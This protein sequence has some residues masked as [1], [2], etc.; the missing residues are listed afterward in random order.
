MS[1]FSV[2]DV[3]RKDRSRCTVTGVIQ[4]ALN[5]R[6]VEVPARR[7]GRVVKSKHLQGTKQDSK[8]FVHD[9]AFG[10]L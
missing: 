5:K 2:D 6:Q 1:V 4:P 10:S 7:V 3:E 8:V 9:R